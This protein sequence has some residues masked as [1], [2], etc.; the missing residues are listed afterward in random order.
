MQRIIEQ[1]GVYDGIASKCSEPTLEGDICGENDRGALVAVSV[2]FPS[3]STAI[4]FVM[5]AQSPVSGI[6]RKAFRRGSTRRLRESC[7]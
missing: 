5:V 2:I 6:S 3:G 1:S 4:T 7:R